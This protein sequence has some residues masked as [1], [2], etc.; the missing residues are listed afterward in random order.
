MLILLEKSFSQGSIITW[1]RI[2]L[3]TPYFCQSI[4]PLF[5]G[6]TTSQAR[7]R[8]HNPGQSMWKSVSHFL[9]AKIGGDHP[10]RAA[11][12]APPDQLLCLLS[13]VSYPTVVGDGL[14]RAATDPALREW[15][16]D[17]R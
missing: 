7:L 10:A 1:G 8:T 14:S 6:C 2:W 11:S 16:G 4:S 5:P 9:A 3:N 17:R 15:E 13:S 12:P